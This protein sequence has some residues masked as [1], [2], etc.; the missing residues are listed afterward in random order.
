[1]STFSLQTACGNFLPE[2]ELENAPSP[3]SSFLPGSM[4]N[5]QRH[6]SVLHRQNQLDAQHRCSYDYR[7]HVNA[8]RQ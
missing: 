2:G 8:D 1:M 6:W 5:R 4:N 7:F 3:G